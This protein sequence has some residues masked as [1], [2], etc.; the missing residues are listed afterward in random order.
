[1]SGTIEFESN[2]VKLLPGRRT[3]V[4]L[5]LDV[6]CCVRLLSVIVVGGR[7]MGSRHLNVFHVR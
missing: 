3:W 5:G 1:M 4:S 6:G 7:T 2:N